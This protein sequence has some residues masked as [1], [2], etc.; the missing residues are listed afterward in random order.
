MSKYNK[1]FQIYPW[2]VEEQTIALSANRQRRLVNLK[3][4]LPAMLRNEV[5]HAIALV[6]ETST[7]P[8]FTTAPSVIGQANAL[9]SVQIRGDGGR[10][11]VDAQG[12]D[13]RALEAYENSGRLVAPDPDLNGGT[14]STFYDVRCIDFGPGEFLG[15][16]SDF[17]MPCVLLK[18][19]VLEAEAPALTDISADTTACTVV[20][21][22]YALLIGLDSVRIPPKV[23]T[24]T[25]TVGG[26]TLELGERALYTSLFMLKSAAHAA[27]ATGDFSALTL[28]D[29]NG[30]VFNNI[31]TAILQRAFQVQM[32]VGQFSPIQGEPRAATDDNSKIVNGATPT[33]LVSPS[34]A[35]QPVLWSAPAS[36]ITKVEV[37]GPIKLRWT[38]SQASA[39]IAL[40]RIMPRGE[41]EATDLAVIVFNELNL[42]FKGGK[43][44]TLSKLPFG[45]PDRIEYMPWDFGYVK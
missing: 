28:D 4:K 42:K 33:A 22:V 39:Y 13:L 20:Q 5:A 7:T 9:R 43:V 37:E 12:P 16:P 15:N 30:N 40:R 41:K 31:S 24:R 6:V 29:R 45:R 23:E 10:V 32:G 14:G 26:N 1:S 2:L 38:G 36:R 25:Y 11:M 8:T 21:R 18:T 34:P 44:K 19:G 35:Y 27:I 3:E 17:A